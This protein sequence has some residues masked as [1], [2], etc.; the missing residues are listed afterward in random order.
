MYIYRVYNCNY[1]KC[2]HIPTYLICIESR[3]RVLRDNNEKLI[4]INSNVD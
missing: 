4:Y 2:T 3:N 1:N